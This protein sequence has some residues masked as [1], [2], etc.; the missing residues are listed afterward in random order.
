MRED[1]KVCPSCP[2]V[3]CVCGAAIIPAMALTGL[4]LGFG[5]LFALEQRLKAEFDKPE[6]SPL[7]FAVTSMLMLAP[8]IFMAI[9]AAIGAYAW[10][11]MDSAETCATKREPNKCSSIVAFVGS[12]FSSCKSKPSELEQIL[13]EINDDEESMRMQRL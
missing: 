8:F 13:A 1:L 2:N 10:G 3:F 5:L 6:M 11:K 9:G 7:S 12:L 4:L